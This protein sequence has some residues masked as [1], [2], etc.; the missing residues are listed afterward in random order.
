MKKY[1]LPQNGRFYKAN[2]HCHTNISDG[3][4]TPE[5]IKKIYKEKGYSIV[6]FTDHNL[7]VPHPELTDEEFLALTGYEI[8]I[9]TPRGSSSSYKTCHICM[10]APTEKD[11]PQVCVHRTK[12][13]N[14]GNK[15]PELLEKLVKYDKNEPDFE[16]EYSH[17]C[18]NRCIAKGRE[19]G[20]FITYNHPTW[21]QESYPEYI[22]YEGMDAMEICNFGCV[23]TG[24]QEYNPR[25]YDDML[26]AGRRIF[27]TATD[28]NHNVK[29][30]SFGGYVYVKADALDYPTVFGALKNGHF[31]SSQGPEIHELYLEGD[32]VTVK[33]SPAREILLNTGVIRAG[34]KTGE[35]GQPITEA[36]FKIQRDDIYFRITV[37]DQNGYPA[38]TNA[39]FTDEWLDV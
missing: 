14:I 19:K 22:G 23:I 32:T 5:E 3:A 30:D 11:T 2:L 31:Y 10:I 27:C 9:S 26:R 25:V 39:Y 13:L 12:Y 4:L 24:W 18:I 29:K 35:D 7:M 16:R 15:Q 37:I 8:N 21:S 20:Y 6:A 1:L 34:I 38:D 33:C 36:T 28:D 17:E